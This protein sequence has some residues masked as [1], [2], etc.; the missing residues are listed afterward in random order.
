MIKK[1]KSRTIAI[2]PNKIIQAGQEM[3]LFQNKVLNAALALLEFNINNSNVES[4]YV[5]EREKE[6]DRITKTTYKIN[7]EAFFDDFNEMKI[8]ENSNNAKYIED[9]LVNLVKQ[10]VLKIREPGSITIISIMDYAHYEYGSKTVDVQFSRMIVPI[11]IDMFKDGFT[12]IRLASMFK[13]RSTY[14]MRL[15]EELLRVK[16]M[17]S[18]IK[19]GHTITIYE[20]FFMLGLDRNKEYKKYDDFRKRV[21]LPIQKEIKEKAGILFEFEEIRKGK[22]VYQIRFYN[23]K[24]DLNFI[25]EGRQLPLFPELE[26]KSVISTPQEE[27]FLKLVLGDTEN[28]VEQKY[29]SEQKIS[30]PVNK[31]NIVLDRPKFTEEQL[32]KLDKYLKDIFSADEI[33]E[34]YDFDYIEFYYIKAKT[35]NEKGTVNDFSNFLYS[36]LINDRYKYYELKRKEREKR[37]KEIVYEKAEQERRE[38][39]KQEKKAKKEQEE[40]KYKELEKIFDSLPDDV[41]KTY[42]EKVYAENSFYAT[43][44]SDGIKNPTKWKVAE[45]VKNEENK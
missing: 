39:E 10:Q 30:E 27:K 11:L 17:D 34:K 19:N 6:I 21:L 13:F 15:Y 1:A 41:K 36:S 20:L 37:E 4:V 3:S 29:A 25:Q 44:D 40:A 26:N 32:D 8:S 2:K 23:I 7:I 12:K 45:M 24:E 42:L 14:S 5:E 9:K 31:E 38:Q 43:I 18:V 22:S 28:I 16:N 33:K 35:M